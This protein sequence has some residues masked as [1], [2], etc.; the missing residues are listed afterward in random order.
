MYNF[1]EEI[2][3]RTYRKWIVDNLAPSD[4]VAVPSNTI[5]PFWIFLVDKGPHLIQLDF[6]DGWGNKWQ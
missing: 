2:E 5:D 3:A 4:N 6:E 1:Y